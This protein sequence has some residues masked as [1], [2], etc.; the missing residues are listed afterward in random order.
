MRRMLLL[1][2]ALSAGAAAAGIVPPTARDALIQEALRGYWGRAKTPDG[3]VITPASEAERT[4]LPVSKKLAHFAFEVGELSGVAEWC[5][6]AW[7]PS[8]SALMRF[9]RK[10]NQSE[11]QVAFIGV[12]HGTA[13]GAVSSAQAKSGQCSAKAKQ[14]VQQRV[15]QFLARE[16][17]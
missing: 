11:R 12:V 15:E 5:G 3:K 1:L 17:K 2:L 9:A 13:Q 4:A 7:Q 6:V 14:Q 10:S 16:P 8:F